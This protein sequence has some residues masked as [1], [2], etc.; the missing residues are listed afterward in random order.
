[1]AE[2][3]PESP[4][5]GSAF[6]EIE[7]Y[8]LHYRHLEPDAGLVPS[9]PVLLVHGFG[10]SIYC[11][12]FLAPE[13]LAAGHPVL[14]VDWPPF[15]YSEAPAGEASGGAEARAR[16]LWSF[17]DAVENAEGRAEGEAWTVVGHSMGGRIAAWMA[18]I[19]PDLIESLVLIAPAIYEGNAP[20]GLFRSPFL[21]SI[22]DANLDR[23]ILDPASIRS[24]L[25]RAYGR[26][27][28]EA[29]FEA[30]WAPFLRPGTHGRLSAWFPVSGDSREPLLAAI[31]APTLIVW[32]SADSVVK[33][34]G[35]RLRKAIAGASSVEIA[36][37]AHLVMESNPAEVNAAIL[38]FLGASRP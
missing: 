21:A 4:F 33:P 25:D 11:W 14:E 19:R 13:L 34:A 32:G 2:Y 37:A 1:M 24:I 7:G 22:I 6:I 17:V 20:L 26:K 9:G 28:S 15:G 35:R 18:A 16:L 3:P 8:R 12:R 38:D 10:S 27:A 5:P 23:R 30:Y 29:D 31:A 36:G